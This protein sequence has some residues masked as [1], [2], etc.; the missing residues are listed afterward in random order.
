M[1]LG[2]HG[3]IKINDKTSIKSGATGVSSRFRDRQSQKNLAQGRL[4][5]TVNPA[6]EKNAAEATI[7]DAQESGQV[8]ISPEKKNIVEDDNQENPNH[9]E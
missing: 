4:S 9:A 2:P 8:E 1:M 7:D 5:Q 6:A 3:A